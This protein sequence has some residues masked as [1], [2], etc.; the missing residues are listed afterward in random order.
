MGRGVYV[1]ESSKKPS[2]LF[3]VRL[4]LA[5]A[6]AVAFDVLVGLD[7]ENGVACCA[8]A[9]AFDQALMACSGP[10]GDAVVV[11]DRSIQTPTSTNATADAANASRDECSRMA[12]APVSRPAA[13]ASSM[14]SFIDCGRVCVLYG[15]RVGRRRW[16]SCMRNS[17]SPVRIVRVWRARAGSCQVVADCNVVVLAVLE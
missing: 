11:H 7:S 3:V 17:G 1:S 2:R 4:E 16:P 5:I 9:A 14:W 6:A 12:A 15:I 13:A 10:A 8:G